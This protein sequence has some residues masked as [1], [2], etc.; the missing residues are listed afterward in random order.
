MARFNTPTPKPPAPSKVRVC[1]F[2]DPNIY[3][4]LKAQCTLD[5]TN[6][7]RWFDEQALYAL[8]QR[9]L[10]FTEAAEKPKRRRRSA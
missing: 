2:V 3:T 5:H 8:N 7:S 9:V 4:R 1:L 6:I 10:G